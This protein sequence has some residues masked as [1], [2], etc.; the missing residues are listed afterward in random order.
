M[1][2]EPVALGRGTDDGSELWLAPARR[3]TPRH[4][5]LA[6][7]RSVDALTRD[8]EL[9]VISHSE[10]G[11]PRYPALRVLRA[12]DTTEEAPAV[13][14]EKWDGDGLGLH[15]LEFGPRPGDRRLLVGTSAAAARSC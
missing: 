5:H 2:P 6:R 13:V 15:A 8:G 7:P 11:D 4:L 10:H 9:L 12:A 14:L 1:R 3:R